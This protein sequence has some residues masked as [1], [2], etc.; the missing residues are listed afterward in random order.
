MLDACGF[1]RAFERQLELIKVITHLRLTTSLSAQRRLDLL[2]L[3]HQCTLSQPQFAIQQ[4]FNLLLFQLG[5]FS[6]DN[7]TGF[8]FDINKV[9]VV[10]VLPLCGELF[11]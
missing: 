2:R 9:A 5:K 3:I 4:V 10:F 7:R 8:N 6:F 11:V 1:N